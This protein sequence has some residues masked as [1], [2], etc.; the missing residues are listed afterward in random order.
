MITIFV[1]YSFRNYTFSLY[2]WSSK[3]TY[4]YFLPWISW[5]NFFCLLKLLNIAPFVYVFG[6]LHLT[7]SLI[8]QVEFLLFFYQGNNCPRVTFALSLLSFICY[9]LCMLNL[10]IN[11]EIFVMNESIHGEITISEHFLFFW[12][13]ILA[14]FLSLSCVKHSNAEYS[15]CLYPK[16]FIFSLV[17]E[18]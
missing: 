14:F 13:I 4:L 3:Y 1:L 16:H 15:L 9:W 18:K 12:I 2:Y 10:W 7:F 5:V 8:S 11:R 6:N 17:M